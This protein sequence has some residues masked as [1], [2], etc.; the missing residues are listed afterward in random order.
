MK[1][2]LQA[3]GKVRMSRR[4]LRRLTS[5]LRGNTEGMSRRGLRRLK[6]NY[7]RR[8]GIEFRTYGTPI[9]IP[10]SIYGDNP[11]PG[12]TLRR[13]TTTTGPR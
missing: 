10:V 6:R 3:T 11:R 4:G 7:D 8:Y 13:L 12:R 9:E 2:P 1:P 5:Y